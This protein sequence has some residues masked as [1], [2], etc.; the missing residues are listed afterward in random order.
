MPEDGPAAGDLAG[1]A[2]AELLLKWD[3]HRCLVLADLVSWFWGDVVPYY[4][5]YFH[6]SQYLMF[7]Q[8]P[9]LGSHRSLSC[10]LYRF[11]KE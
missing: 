8:N 3:T 6:I 10:L 1:G 2:A 4:F 9:C 5:W 11:A 7:L